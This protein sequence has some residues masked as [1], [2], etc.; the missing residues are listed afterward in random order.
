MG[1]D[2][3]TKV[4]IDSRVEIVERLLGRLRSWD[5][6]MESAVD[7][8]ERNQGDYDQLKCAN[9]KLSKFNISTKD[10]QEYKEKLEE[11]V[12]EQRKL[13]QA[14][15]RGQDNLLKGMKELGKKSKVMNSYISVNQG[16]IFVDKDA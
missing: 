5:G 3:S 14:L 2:I 4:L 8:V 6:I 16:T 10:E 7:L 1:A 13:S 11:L 15:K 9:E 12:K